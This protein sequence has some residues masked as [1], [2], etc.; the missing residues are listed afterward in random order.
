MGGEFLQDCVFF[1]CC[2]NGKIQKGT[3]PVLEGEAWMAQ[4]W[5]WN[6]VNLPLPVLL[7]FA[8]TRSLAATPSVLPSVIARLRQRE[9]ICQDRLGTN[10]KSKKILSVKNIAGAVLF[11]RLPLRRIRP[12]LRC[13]VVYQVRKRYFLSRLYI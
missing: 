9:T 6:G 7:S 1:A 8:K 11:C 3:C 2:F 13:V 4:M 10:T 12:R 5:V